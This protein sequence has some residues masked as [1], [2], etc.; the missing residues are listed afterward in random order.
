MQ[1]PYQVKEESVEESMSSGDVS[2]DS[3]DDSSRG[4]WFTERELLKP[5]TCPPQALFDSEEEDEQEDDSKQCPQ[6][7]CIFLLPVHLLGRHQ[8]HFYIL[9]GL[10]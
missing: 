4:S 1:E 2:F 5:H 6:Q 7:V 10:C 3:H 9:A 8:N